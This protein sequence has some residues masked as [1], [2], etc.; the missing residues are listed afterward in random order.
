[1]KADEET[2]QV[3]ARLETVETLLQDERIAPDVKQEVRQHFLQES[4]SSHSVD[5][6]ALFR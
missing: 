4:Q 3:R 6:A 1:M 2:V 5:M